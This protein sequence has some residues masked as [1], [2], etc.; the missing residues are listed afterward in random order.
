MSRLIDVE[1]MKIIKLFI[2]R[3]Y[4]FQIVAENLI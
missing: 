3:R 4:K 1:Y 2:N